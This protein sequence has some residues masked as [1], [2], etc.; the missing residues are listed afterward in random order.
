MRKMSE[1]IWLVPALIFFIY[2]MM[3]R[4]IGSGTRFFFVWL[5]LA[6]ICVLMMPAAHYGVWKLLPGI[7]RKIIII[8]LCIGVI[9]FGAVEGCVMSHFHDKGAEN[10]DYLIVLGAQVREDGPSNVLRFRLDKAAEYLNENKDTR[11]IVSGGQ[12]YNE[13][14]SEAEGMADYLIAKG[15]PEDRILLENRS[16]STREN[17]RFSRELMESDRVLP[18]SE[19]KSICVITNDFH[20]FRALQTAEA[21]GLENVSGSSAGSVKIYLPN[22][23]LREYMGE[24]KYLLDPAK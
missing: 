11:C 12:G 20:M 16:M 18:Y 2:G 14:F 22:N 5:G 13:P 6:A 10:A 1:M 3:I 15:I 21:E 19:V 23:L 9:S 7:V 17:M 8:L 4:A 24:I